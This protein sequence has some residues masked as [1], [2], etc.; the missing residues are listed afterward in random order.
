MSEPSESQDTL[1][2]PEN[3][4]LWEKPHTFGVRSAVS[5]NSPVTRGKPHAHI[6]S[7]D[8]VFQHLRR[9]SKSTEPRDPVGETGLGLCGLSRPRRSTG[10]GCGKRS[11]FPQ[12][13]QAHSR[14][15]L[16][17]RS[18]GT[19]RSSL[20]GGLLGNG[21]PG[22]A[23]DKGALCRDP[24][25]AG[26]SRTVSSLRASTH[27]SEKEA[28]RSPCFS[29]VSGGKGLPSTLTS[30]PRRINVPY[31]PPVPKPCTLLQ[32]APTLL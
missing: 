13:C 16:S 10:S 24:A 2:L 6:P 1:L 31:L 14:A 5:S 9:N 8:T 4:P 22:G 12:S 19:S 17:A 28:G 3:W 29:E 30:H 27:L 7:L 23:A 25:G 21:V 26:G 18:R 20:T 32:R 15:W 11:H